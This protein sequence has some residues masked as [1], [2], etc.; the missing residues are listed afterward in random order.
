VSTAAHTLTRIS[1]IRNLHKNSH[2]ACIHTQVQQQQ[3]P[4]ATPA[5]TT[6]AAAAAAAAA[7]GT[8]F[9]KVSRNS[10]GWSAEEDTVIRNAVAACGKY[11]KC[12]MYMCL[13]RL[14]LLRVAV[15]LGVRRM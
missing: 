6:A 1:C 13:Q 2:F 4:P 11:F 15:L 8:P 14:Y 3:P 12:C 7:A 9:A 5:A 10:R